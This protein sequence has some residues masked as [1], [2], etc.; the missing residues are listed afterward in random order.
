[1]QELTQLRDKIN[2]IDSSLLSL[3]AERIAVVKEV[4]EFKKQNNIAI[5]DP[6]REEELLE[7]LSEKAR[8]QNI[9]PDFVRSLWKVIFAESYTVEK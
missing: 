6:K 2:T 8:N 3:L 9:S 4:G 1:M 7:T 5:H